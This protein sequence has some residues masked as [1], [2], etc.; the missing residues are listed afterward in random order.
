MRGWRRGWREEGCF[1]TSTTT[2]FGRGRRRRK[3]WRSGEAGARVDGAL[4]AFGARAKPL[5]VCNGVRARKGKGGGRVPEKA[6]IMIGPVEWIVAIVLVS[7]VQI[8][9][10]ARYSHA[11]VEIGKTGHVLGHSSAFHAVHARV[12]AGI[13]AAPAKGA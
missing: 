10:T 2:V 5:I 1:S 8:V 13:G 4:P 3:A 12:G 9:D 11:R 6:V 7:S